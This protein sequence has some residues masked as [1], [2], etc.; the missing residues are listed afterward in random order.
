MQSTI[1]DNIPEIVHARAA[2]ENLKIIRADIDFL[3]SYYEK[4][5]VELE[6]QMLAVSTSTNISEAD[7]APYLATIENYK[8]TLANIENLISY[9]ELYITAAVL[10]K[11]LPSSIP[12]F[13]KASSSVTLEHDFVKDFIKHCCV[14]C[15]A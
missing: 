11:E 6:Y 9:Y 3:Q 8:T 5:E 4:V 7:K 1:E 15:C 12:S 10:K 14:T 2:T 13:Y